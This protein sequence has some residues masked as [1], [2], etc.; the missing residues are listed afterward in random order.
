[1]KEM[2]RQRG[3]GKGHLFGSSG[4]GGNGIVEVSYNERISTKMV[5]SS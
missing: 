5:Q 3:I 4:K 1:M 2:K